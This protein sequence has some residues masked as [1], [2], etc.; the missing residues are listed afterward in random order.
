MH[1][2]GRCMRRCGLYGDPSLAEWFTPPGSDR[3][4]SSDSLIGVPPLRLQMAAIEAM[5]APRWISL[6]LS[7]LDLSWQ[8]SSIMP[9]L[10]VEIQGHGTLFAL[11]QQRDSRKADER[12]WR[13]W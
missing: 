5:R 2:R 7:S 8:Q 13:S 12:E 10:W 11:Q 1:G 4:T 6:S 3:A 9:E